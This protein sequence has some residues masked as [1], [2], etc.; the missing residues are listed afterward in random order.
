MRRLK[1]ICYFLCIACVVNAQKSK[2]ISIVVSE[3]DSRYEEMLI[4]L[5]LKNLAESNSIDFQLFHFNEEEETVSFKGAKEKFSEQALILDPKFSNSLKPE[6]I[7]SKDT[8]GKVTNAYM[9]VNLDFT[10]NYKLF[11]IG[12]SRVLSAKQVVMDP[13]KLSMK[14]EQIKIDTKK[15]FT[16]KLPKKDSK[17]YKEMEKRVY[18]EYGLRI[19]KHYENRIKSDYSIIREIRGDVLSLSD[20]KPFSVTPYDSSKKRIKSFEMNA[21]KDQDINKLDAVHVFK[22]VKIGEMDGFERL[23]TAVVSQVE[24]GTSK[25]NFVISG[26]KKLKEAVAEEAV[27]YAVRNEGLLNKEVSN[28][29]EVFRVTLKKSCV[30]C[31]FDIQEQLADLYFINYIDRGDDFISKY[32]IESYKTEKFIDNDVENVVGRKEGVGYIIGSSKE[33]IEI[34]NTQTGQL[35]T[36]SRKEIKNDYRS[37][38]LKVF[39][40]RLK[41]VGIAKQKKDRIKRIYVYS[42]YGFKTSEYLK[43]SSV[44]LEEVGGKK[45]ERK[46][47]IGNGQFIKSHSELI[48]EIILQKNEKAI[49]KAIQD[50]STLH[51]EY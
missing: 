46:T 5:L 47:E 11:D 16:G 8:T 31:D 10:C 4:D 44:Y 20:E 42:P 28:K 12:S 41:Y 40:P 43:I 14:S 15:F 50:G 26:G 37:L 2:V 33:N 13:S 23:G 18:A 29:E 9:D 36:Q 27:V 7:L 1:T 38:F 21:G 19:A 6:I 49:S 30:F 17:A 39:E 22:K 34:T 24:S 51:F 45:Y 25:A 32:F 35:L 3:P 48:G